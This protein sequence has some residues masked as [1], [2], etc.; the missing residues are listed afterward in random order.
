MTLTIELL[1]SEL[2]KVRAA[3]AVRGVELGEFAVAAVMDAADAVIEGGRA[4]DAAPATP[5]RI[6]WERLAAELAAGLPAERVPLSDRAV[7]RE[8]IYEDVGEG[9]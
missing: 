1:E 3:A 5:D 8:G 2:S 6:R 9:R 7:S 4:D